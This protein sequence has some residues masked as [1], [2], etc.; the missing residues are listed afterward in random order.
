MPRGAMHRL[1]PMVKARMEQAGPY[2]EAF[3]CLD[4]AD[5]ENVRSW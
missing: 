3:L 4:E 5:R 2:Y 1:K